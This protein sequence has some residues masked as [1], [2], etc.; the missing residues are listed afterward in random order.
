MKIPL[1]HV[2][3]FTD[4]LVSGN[5]AA[6]CLLDSWL[7]DAQ[8]RKVAA[9]NNLPATAFLVPAT[10]GYSLRW[11]TGVSELKLC[12]HATFASGYVVLNRLRPELDSVRFSTQSRGDLT[13]SKEDDRLAMSFPALV[14]KSCAPSPAV[15][16]ALGPTVQP[17]DIV[18]TLEVFGIY[19]AV[20]GSQSAV[21]NLRPHQAVL[22]QLHPL[23]LSVT[24][25]GE[26][27]DVD[28]VSRYFAPGYG[29]PED[30]VTGSAHAAL[31]PYW[32]GRTGKTQLHARQLSPRGGEVWCE[33]AGDRVILKGRAVYFMEGSL[34]I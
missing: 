6:V 8:L 22:E 20:L 14:A 17:S 16:Q 34:T 19:I 21:R 28:F 9:E 10:N 7:D 24:A 13:V 27:E 32:A 2:D 18:E 12:G 31:A 30:S 11:F 4:H 23:T 1:F 25:E 15:I 5:P 26:G 29:I 33:L 3:A